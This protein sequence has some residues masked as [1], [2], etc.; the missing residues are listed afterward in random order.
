MADP[1]PNAA[2][3]PSGE[4]FELKGPP[5]ALVGMLEVAA[6][7]MAA[8]DSGSFN[9]GL[10]EKAHLA[11]AAGVAPGDMAVFD[12]DGVERTV[13]TPPTGDSPFA[14]LLKSN[15]PPSRRPPRALRI[16][17]AAPGE[18]RM[19]PVRYAVDPL[20][21]PGGYSATF[22]VGQA[23]REARIVVLP[24][25]GLSIEPRQISLSGRPGEAVVEDLVLE[26]TGNTPI[27]LG[28]LGAMV[29]EED[30]QVCLSLQHAM[31][32]TGEKGAM[33]FLDAFASSLAD[34]KTD[35]V[36][37]AIA[38]GGLRLLPGEAR[39]V[40]VAFHLPEN[41]KPGRRYHALLKCGSAQLSTQIT[42]L[43]PNAPTAKVRKGET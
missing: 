19:T 9:L 31:A 28:A 20:T 10:F 3:P 34:R 42:V 36:R 24:Q 37:V 35:L 17:R 33:G 6:S 7:P 25:E 2:T 11:R 14:V 5:G 12:F 40:A 38:S 8:A 29:T 39:Q 13:A 21:P 16:G 30:E 26:N 22:S 41:M 1:P 18:T 4:P 43:G 15:L 23:Q 32:R 27:E